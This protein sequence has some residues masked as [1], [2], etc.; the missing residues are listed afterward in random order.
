MQSNKTEDAS[1]QKKRKLWL[2]PIYA[3]SSVLEFIMHS[4]CNSKPG[5]LLSKYTTSHPKIT[6]VT[7]VTIW[8]VLWI[9]FVL[10]EF[11][12][13]FLTLS[14]IC[15]L[16]ANTRTGPKTDN[17]PS[18][19]SVFNENCERIAGTFT[20]EQFDNHLRRGGGLL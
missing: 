20:A 15:L 18:A 3:L 12:I 1:V 16:Y 2:C 17:A 5:K 6:I 7:K 10:I 13:V 11:G 8:L 4:I 14:L 19:Y 9:G